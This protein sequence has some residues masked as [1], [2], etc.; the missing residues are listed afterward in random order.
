M[1]LD[2]C[3]DCGTVLCQ[4]SSR[5]HKQ[6]IINSHHSVQPLSDKYI[7]NFKLSLDEQATCISDVQCLPN[8]FIV[9]SYR[10]DNKIVILSVNGKKKHCTR[11]TINTPIFKLT[12]VDA[13]TVMAILNPSEKLTVATS[14]I[15]H[16]PVISNKYMNNGNIS[17][18]P[19]WPFLYIEQL[20]YI[21]VNSQMIVMNMS[22]CIERRM[23]LSF[24]P[25]DICNDINSRR[26][27]CVDEKHSKLI[28]I[29]MNGN[30]IFTLNFTDKNIGNPCSLTMD[31]DGNV[32]VL[33]EKECCLF[34]VIKVDPDR[35]STDI[36]ITKLETDSNPIICFDSTTKSVIIG[37]DDT[38]Y[39]YKKRTTT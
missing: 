20:F 34:H 24:T 2:L 17:W 22:G 10:T 31:D 9:A 27:Y 18:D 23:D 14:S 38:F 11:V 29:D 35:K 15:R 30:T 32:I 25:V 3:F 39:I 16:T 26:I 8:G 12:V 1:A 33:S 6:K 28:C 7:I 19:K 4:K 21:V 37:S 5:K 36:I 13:D